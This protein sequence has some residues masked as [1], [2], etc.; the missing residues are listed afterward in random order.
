MDYLFDQIYDKYQ[1]KFKDLTKKWLRNHITI[2][3]K[4]SIINPS[5]NSQ[6]KEELM[7]PYTKLGIVC[8]LTNAFYK[9]LNTDHLKELLNK[10]NQKLLSKQDSGKKSRMKGIPK[11]EDANYAGTKKSLDCVLI[12]TEGDSAKASAISGISA[13]SGGRN[14][15]GVY[16]LRGKMLNVRTASTSMINKNEEISN[17]RKIMGFQSGMDYTKD[18]NM[19]T[20]RYGS[21]LLMMDADVDGSHIKGLFLNFIDYLYPTLLKVEGFIQVLVTPVIR[22]T[23]GDKVEK[24]RSVSDYELWK[25]GKDVSKWHVKYYKGLGT[26][27]AKESAEYFTE[28]N[29]HV[30]SIKNITPGQNPEILKAFDKSKADE[31]KS[32]LS[33]YDDTDTINFKPGKIVT[34]NEFIN[35]ELVHFSNYDNIRSIPNL[36]DGLKPSQRKILYACFKRNLTNEIK[37]QQLSGYVSEVSSYLHGETS[38]AMAIISM[39]QNFVGSNN[40]NLLDPIGQFGTRLLNGNDS[41]SPRYIYTKLN[42]LTRKIFRTED[43]ELLINQKLD[44]DTIEPVF[45]YPIIPMLLVNG[46]TGIGTGYSST[47]PN[48][49]VTDIIGA[50]RC[51]LSKKPCSD[52]VPHYN[53]FKGTIIK[54]GNKIQTIGNYTIEGNK[55]IITELPIGTATSR[56]KEFIEEMVYDGK[57]PFSSVNNESSDVDVKFTLKINDMEQI[58]A[59]ESVV[60][61]GITDTVK[62]L[63]LITS[64]SLANMTIYNTKNE[65]ITYANV[66]AIINDFYKHR[67]K[68]YDFRKDILTQKYKRQL[69]MNEDKVRWIRDV[70][71]N[72]IDLM[73]SSI[74]DITK[75]LTKNKYHRYK[76]SYDYLVDITIREMTHE[77]IMK[78]GQKIK[79]LKDKYNS[80][81]SS[82]PESLWSSDLDDLVSALEKISLESMEETTKI[83][84]GKKKAKSKSKSK[85][86]KEGGYIDIEI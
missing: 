14:Y 30:H 39:A 35:K 66:K 3:L 68:I 5:F 60:V 48:Y 59:L 38:L 81:I 29:D 11:L 55:L 31:R 36:M 49:S 54:H 67:I 34:I 86:P 25:I 79:D 71:T 10:S 46:A 27:T 17:I 63:K 62:K 37:V 45:Y 83:D 12:L 9:R 42:T 56:Y 78:L 43:D 84:K 74:D 6:T 64:I 57:S 70:Q 73:K 22:A 75:Y 77:Y 41:A 13:V 16:P 20:L 44:G 80:I 23:R 7:T 40:L 47:V 52:L 76:N 82:T 33:S 18:G 4:S 24:F 53:G 15:Y 50:I 72:K 65:I 85:S 2:V 51:K 28:Y 8:D 32:W 19:E 58:N 21:I 1:S 26:S 69:L 61:N